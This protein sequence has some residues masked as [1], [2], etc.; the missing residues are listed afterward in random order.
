V[1]I[2][3]VGAKASILPT[4]LPAILARPPPSFFPFQNQDIKKLNRLTSPLPTWLSHQSSIS[5]S[6]VYMERPYQKMAGPSKPVSFGTIRNNVSLKVIFSYVL[7]WIVLIAFGFGSLGVGY[8]T[9]NKRPFSLN[10]PNISFPYAETETVPSWL[11]LVLVAIVPIVSVFVVAIIF[12]PGATV[13]RNT[14]RSLVWRRKL[15][16]LHVGWMGL[17]LS[18]VIAFFFTQGMKNMFGKPRPD[19][20]DRCQPDI[21]NA[22]RYVVGGFAGENPLGLLYS[23]GICKQSDHEKLDDGFRS[24]PS[25]HSS[26]AAAG[27]VYLSLFLA[28]K[29]AV[30]IPFVVPNSATSSHASRTAF[31]SRSLSDHKASVHPDNEWDGESLVGEHNAKIQS[32]R[33]QAAAP[34]LYLLALTLIPFGTSV[35]I[36]ASRWWDFRHHGFDILFG[37]LMG[38][39]SAIYAFRY[40]H[41]SIQEGAGWAWGPRSDDRAFWAGVGRVGYVGESSGVS[42]KTQPR[43]RSVL[44]NDTVSQS[45]H[46]QPEPSYTGQRQN[47]E[48]HLNEEYYPRPP[49]NNAYGE[50]PFHD[51]EMQRLNERPI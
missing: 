22:A 9:P 34:P 42:K 14:P 24:Y 20:L 16:E 27:L 33:R 11:L 43:H 5:S 31:P 49:P 25:G 39:L 6:S 4:K 18:L 17:A 26:S 23:A 13:P 3:T 35:F 29:F 48:A 8:I 38:L 40:Y 37:W 2:C 36:A 46:T 41:L 21:E 19:L 12:V 47:H 45:Q 30:T 50:G 44:S 1:V 10:D 7:D 15:W 51:V 28:S 32:I